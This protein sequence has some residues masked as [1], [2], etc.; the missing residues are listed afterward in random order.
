MF[1][2]LR[3]AQG[4]AADG[5]LV[6]FRQQAFGESAGAR[7]IGG[8]GLLP[9]PFSLSPAYLFLRAVDGSKLNSA[10]AGASEPPALRARLRAAGVFLWR[11]NWIVVLAAFAAVG[12]AIFDDYGLAFDDLNQRLLGLEALDHALRALGLP[13]ERELP[14]DFRRFFGVAFEI[15][16]ALGEMALGLRDTREIILFRHLASHLFFLTGGVFA[17]LLARRMFAGSPIA[18]LFAMLLFLLHPRIYAHSFYNTKDPVFLAAFVIALYAVHR[19]FGRNSLSAFALCGIA[20]GLLTNVR[21]LGAILFPAVLGMLALD[22]GRAAFAALRRR[23]SGEETRREILSVSARA[24]VFALSAALAL[25][26]TWPFLWGKSPLAF[27]DGFGILANH[28]LR[29]YQVF[30]GDVYPNTNLPP[31]F[32]PVWIAATTPLMTLALAALGIC[33]TVRTGAR[34]PAEALGNSETRFRLLLVAC[35]ALTLIALAAIRPNVYD[36]WR[37]FYF[38]YAPVCLLAVCGLRPLASAAR[39]LWTRPALRRLPAALRRTRPAL[40]IYSAAALGIALTAVEIVAIHPNQGLYFNAAVDKRALFYQWEQLSWGIGPYQWMRFLLD[41]YPDSD[42][43]VKRFAPYGVA[44]LPPR[45]R[46]RIVK[47]G[48]TADFYVTGHREIYMYRIGEYAEPFAPILYQKRIYGNPIMSVL[49]VNLDWADGE[50]ADAYR[51]MFREVSAGEP[52]VRA[53]YDVYLREDAVFYLKDRCGQEDERG[54]FLAGSAPVRADD[55]SRFYRDAGYNFTDFDFHLYGVRFDGKCM[56]RYPLPDYETRAVEIGR[57]FEGDDAAGWRKVVPI[58]PSPET[59]E[60]WRR[61]YARASEGDAIVRSRFDIYRDG[62]ELVY[63]RES[64]AEEDTRGRFFVNFSPAN[65]DG[66]PREVREVEGESREAALDQRG[67]FFSRF[68]RDAGYEYDFADFDFH[69]HG[70]RFDGKCMI[71]YPLPDYGIR[72]FETGRPPAGG[73]AAWRESA[74]LPPAPE[75]LEKWRREYARASEGEAIVRSRF[76]IYRDG[77]TLIYLKEPCAE[78]DARGRFLVSVFPANADDLPGERRE[79]GHESRNFTFS[80][81]GV[82]AGGICAARVSLPAYPI[83][84]LELGQWLPGGDTIWRETVDIADGR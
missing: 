51:R 11:R 20:V 58:P 38:L 34:R 35:L 33:A 3:F 9:S 53:D 56:V 42:L 10:V 32:I 24:A 15:P 44:F 12:L 41:A 63:L 19:A 40:A 80:N 49:A 6:A 52:V 76:D 45:D 48:A 47:G 2:A 8:A 29:T 25:Y 77:D 14:T 22:F 62:D 72:A 57:F 78:E 17:W 71:R 27:V 70:V 55:V 7:Q 54:R 18:A 74:S 75:T 46:G 36:G 69:I 4:V 79:P 43:S 81:Q 68:Y 39:S 1:F 28:P 73:A 64:C 66:L 13:A 30:W 50:V 37:Q 60:K 67:K 59:L 84:R 26:A 82:H 5:R 65:A 16:L 23:G 21:I 83:K 31:H 61:E